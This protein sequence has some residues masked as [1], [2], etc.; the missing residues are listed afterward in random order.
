MSGIHVG[1]SICHWWLQQWMII[2]SQLINLC[3]SLPESQFGWPAKPIAR[4]RASSSCLVGKTWVY[5]LLQW[6]HFSSPSTRMFFGVKLHLCWILW[7]LKRISI[8]WH[9]S[10]Q[11]LLKWNLSKKL[12]ASQSTWRRFDLWFWMM[13]SKYWPTS[14][15]ASSQCP[16]HVS[17]QLQCQWCPWQSKSHQL[18]Q[19][20]QCS[21]IKQSTWTS[22]PDGPESDPWVMWAPHFHLW[23]IRGAANHHQPLPMQEPASRRK[24]H[25]SSW[26]CTSSSTSFFYNRFCFV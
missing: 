17:Q 16:P 3:L 6:V 21:S 9:W 13:N 1:G 22:N 8:T 7:R 12:L 11:C 23:V 4:N 14:F 10:L 5:Q 15:H 26:S 20:R 24:N 2:I 25:S 19:A 18:I